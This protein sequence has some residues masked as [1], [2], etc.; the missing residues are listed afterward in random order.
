MLKAL[1]F[2][3]LT[4][5]ALLLGHI[6]GNI[7]TYFKMPRNTIDQLAFAYGYLT[8]QIIL[9]VICGFMVKLGVKV[10]KLES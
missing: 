4:I 9:F 6:I 10:I 8:W 7:L 3:C 5:G 2:I 1:G